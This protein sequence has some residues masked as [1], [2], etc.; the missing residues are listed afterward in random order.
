M[1]N[2]EYKTDWERA[3][4]IAFY[5]VSPYAKRGS[6]HSVQDLFRFDWEKEDL[7]ELTEEQMNYCLTKLRKFVDENGN[8]YNA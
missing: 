5:A 4:L 6:L 7:P 2:I 8:F 1:K 3:R